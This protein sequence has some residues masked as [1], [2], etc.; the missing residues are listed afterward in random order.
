MSPA[1]VMTMVKKLEQRMSAVEQILPTLATKE[2]LKAFATKEDLKAFATK[3]DLK[4]FATKE[5]LKNFPT[6]AEMEEKFEDAKRFALVLHE[7]LKSDIALL[8]EHLADVMRRL[9]PRG[10]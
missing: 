8:A 9:P 6:R 3:E 4:A 7:D 10:H 1:V 2:D 5:D